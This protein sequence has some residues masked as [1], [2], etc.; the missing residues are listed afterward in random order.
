MQVSD[1]VEMAHSPDGDFLMR[2]SSPAHSPTGQSV[3]LDDHPC[4]MGPDA[5]PT[6]VDYGANHSHD[7]PSLTPHVLSNHSSPSTSR[8]HRDQHSFRA[9][10]DAST[11]W[12]D[13]R[14]SIEAPSPHYTHA[15]DRDASILS[16][17][18]PRSAVDDDTVY[19]SLGVNAGLER[20]S[21]DGLGSP[22]SDVDYSTTGQRDRGSDTNGPTDNANRSY[23][24]DGSVN[25]PVQGN[26]DALPPT[27]SDAVPI[28]DAR[29]L[30]E[31]RRH[32]AHQSRV[33]EGFND[34]A[35]APVLYGTRRTRC[36]ICGRLDAIP[37]GPDW[38]V[39]E[40]LEV[41]HA[42]TMRTTPDDFDQIP[43]AW[44][45]CECFVEPQGMGKHVAEVHLQ[46]ERVQCTRCD[47]S[48]ARRDTYKRHCRDVHEFVL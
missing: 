47:R 30:T 18:A 33:N 16:L 40:H 26:P 46:R 31:Q 41:Y 2:L 48:F 14:I 42:D 29:Y 22:P 24:G 25:F 34:V 20:Q 12:D 10:L 4:A 11:D 7:N 44:P 9:A 21:Q 28:N 45:D 6:P 37:E 36:E 38:K 5:S 8:T 13:A 23:H 3:T 15:Q 19:P 1:D 35:S 27:D 17:G 32:L 39:Q 43:C